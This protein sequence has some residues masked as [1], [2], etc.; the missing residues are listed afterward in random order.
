MFLKTSIPADSTQVH[1]TNMVEVIY[2]VQ[3][4]A[5][6]CT[7]GCEA[8]VLGFKIKTTMPNSISP[9]SLCHSFMGSTSAPCAVI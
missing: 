6:S 1:H 7:R 3:S 2:F 4:S 8:D 5:P 9:S